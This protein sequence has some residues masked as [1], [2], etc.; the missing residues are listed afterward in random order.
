M[1]FGVSTDIA[2]SGWFFSAYIFDSFFVGA[3]NIFL[4]RITVQSEGRWPGPNHLV[5]RNSCIVFLI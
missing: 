2:L 4:A 3:M 1:L 5:Q